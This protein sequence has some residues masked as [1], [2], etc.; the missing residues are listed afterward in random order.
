MT[1][2][3]SAA[4]GSDDAVIHKLGVRIFH[5]TNSVAFLFLLV[6]GINF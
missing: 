2:S 6:S 3:N 4:I 5:W 1:S